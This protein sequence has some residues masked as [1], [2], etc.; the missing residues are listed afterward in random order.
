MVI[1]KLISIDYFPVEISKAIRKA[2]TSSLF[3]KSLIAIFDQALL[4]CVNFLVAII[5]IKNV[6]KS[7]YGY[8]SIA[9][10]I[11]LFLVSIQNAVVTT[12]LTVLLVSKKDNDRQNYVRALCWGQFIVLLPAVGVGLCVICV[13]WFFGF[14]VI[15]TA[16]AGC[17]CLASI[18]IMLQEFLRAY[19]FAEEAPHDAL[20]LDL[21]YIAIYLSLI[22]FTLLC[23]NLSVAAIFIFIGLSA[24]LVYI[25]NKRRLPPGFNWNLIKES[26]SEN[27]KFGRWALLG[28][29]TTH[30]HKYSYLYMLGA[31]MGSVAVA[32]VSAS[33]LLLIPFLLVQTGWGKVIRPHGARLREDNQLKRYFM[34]LVVASLSGGFAIILYAYTILFFTGYLGDL[35]YTQNYEGAFDYV[36]LWGAIVS[37]TFIRM[38]AG[39]GLQ[40]L[41]KFNSVA[42]LSTVTMI[43]TLCSAF[44]F[45]KSYGIEGALAA[46]F[47]GE[48]ILACTLWWI[49]STQILLTNNKFNKL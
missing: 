21:Y 14:D 30:I 36:L 7:E 5:L 45:I 37:I 33:R 3:I 42:K 9:F 38:N 28:V 39:S 12:P 35:L 47:L 1:T 27:W 15:K 10:A 32:D 24:G 19:Y 26:Y 48:V 11:S 2:L 18:G 34:E 13:M 43:V 4:S 17:L 6:S 31:L 23:F 20:K 49:L 16:I 29:I 25:I 40:V 44:F 46:I 41:K 8:Y 22:A